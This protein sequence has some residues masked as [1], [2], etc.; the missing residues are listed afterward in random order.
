MRCA[1]S[2][3]CDFAQE[4]GGKI[5]ALGIGWTDI[6]AP[7]VPASHPQMS[8]VA[9]LHGTIAE[10]GTKR[11][12]LR[13]IDADGADVIPGLEADLEFI[14]NEPALEGRMNLV[15]GFN[16]VEFPRF[17]QY[18]FH[19]VVQGNEMAQERFTVTERPA[20]G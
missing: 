8:F 9:S 6:H 14:V 17:G 5:H 15:F 13:L 11:V 18:A 2:F 7:P 16:G 1:Y 20:A 10:A 3:L 12:E 4:S 19:L